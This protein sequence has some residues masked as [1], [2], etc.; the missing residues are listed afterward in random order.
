M[1]P[2]CKMAGNAGTGQ[3]VCILV[4]MAMVR[5]QCVLFSPVH[6]AACLAVGISHPVRVSLVQEDVDM[7]DVS[8]EGVSHFFAVVSHSA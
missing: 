3:L 5:T 1:T 6:A 4:T 8:Q 2:N 7:E